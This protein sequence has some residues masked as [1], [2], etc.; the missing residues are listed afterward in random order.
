MCT[1]RRPYFGRRIVL[2]FDDWLPTQ[3][4]IT[5]YVTTRQISTVNVEWGHSVRRLIFLAG[6]FCPRGILS[7]GI[8]SW[9]RSLCS[10]PT[11]TPL[12]VHYTPHRRDRNLHTIAGGSV[13]KCCSAV[14][15]LSG[16]TPTAG[17]PHSW[18][19]RRR[20]AT[21]NELRLSIRVTKILARAGGGAGET[22]STRIF[23]LIY[24]DQHAKNLVTISHTV[25]AHVVHRVSKK[26]RTPVTFWHNS[27]ILLYASNTWYGETVYNSMFVAGYHLKPLL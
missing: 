3:W 13:D 11:A 15:S 6:A 2:P 24:F 5:T 7:G 23:F 14:F 16:S 22:E 26:T 20:L 21:A 19:Q 12:C 4:K 1:H 17:N 27:P 8:M 10:S 9:I 18:I 25:C